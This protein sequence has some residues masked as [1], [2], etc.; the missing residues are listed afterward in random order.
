MGYRLA[1]DML[2]P[3][4]QSVGNGGAVDRFLKNCFLTLSV[5]HC[6]AVFAVEVQKAPDAKAWSESFDRSQLERRNI[7]HR[8]LILESLRHSS[9]GA[10]K[11]VPLDFN[12]DMCGQVSFL[13]CVNGADFAYGLKINKLPQVIKD[14]EFAKFSGAGGLI[15]SDG[16]GV[17]FANADGKEVITIKDAPKLT[18]K[19]D[20]RR[21]FDRLLASLGYDGIVL[22]IKGDYLLVGTFD[23]RLKKRDLQGLLIKRS[24]DSL[25]INSKTSKEGGALLSLVGY[26]G[27]YAVFKSI[28]GGDAVKLGQK[29][30]IEGHR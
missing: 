21:L 12:S 8:V 10:V 20:A 18:Q 15:Y 24:A 2:A 30:L 4:W 16:E 13:S 7:P 28:I 17:V 9:A 6:A 1:V 26:Y 27:G 29:V 22:D 14:T 11:V 5:M 25:V 23:A 19:L 3:D